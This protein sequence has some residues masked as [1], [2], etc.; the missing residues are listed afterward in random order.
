MRFKIALDKIRYFV[1]QLQRV[2]S[3]NRAQSKHNKTIRFG[4]ASDSNGLNLC[5][6]VGPATS[7]KLQMMPE[8][9]SSQ[10]SH[11]EIIFSQNSSLN[12]NEIN[13]HLIFESIQVKDG[14]LVEHIPDIIMADD[15]QSLEKFDLVT[16]YGIEHVFAV[17]CYTLTNHDQEYDRVNDE[18][19][20]LGEFKR[21]AFNIPH[22]CVKQVL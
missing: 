1:V 22:Y 12:R 10:D 19:M 3:E 15:V 4:G 13:S 17:H 21:L 5:S 11:S 18:S 6:S 16:K 9:A 20:Q 7:K 2:G 14:D 8:I